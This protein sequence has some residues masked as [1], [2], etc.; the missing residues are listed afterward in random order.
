MLKRLICLF[1][2]LPATAAL[3]DA[4]AV[5]RSKPVGTP[6]TCTND[7]PESAVWDG[8]EGTTVLAFRIG[9]DGRIKNI[10]IA[11][12][13]GH[14]DFDAASLGCVGR[15]TYTPA[16]RDGVAVEVPWQ[17]AVKWEMHA[18][19]A[20][21]HPCAKYL[22]VTKE[23]LA[24]N[25]GVSKISFR[26][27]PDGTVK[28]AQLASSSGNDALDRAALRCIAERRFNTQRAVLP[29]AGIAKNVMIDWRN[30]LQAV[31]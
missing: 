9:T 19:A 22:T 12:S 31:K 21:M 28:D 26:I 3:A 11:K 25:G 7:Y 23:L 5:E 4:S 16:K 6:H 20:E 8:A 30:D 17:A 13:S 24:G 15:W 1:L 2:A 18:S 29:D 14:E 10:T 27:M